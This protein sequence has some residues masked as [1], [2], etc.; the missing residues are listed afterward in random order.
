MVKKV[1]AKIPTGTF[2]KVTYRCVASIPRYDDCRAR[3]PGPG[4]C[5]DPAT[6]EQ[7]RS[8]KGSDWKPKV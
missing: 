6:G 5:K 4:C 7:C 1:T 8:L 3:S 2:K